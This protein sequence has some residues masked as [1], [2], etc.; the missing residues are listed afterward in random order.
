MGMDI[1]LADD[2]FSYVIPAIV[3]VLLVYLVAR[4]RRVNVPLY[5]ILAI[6]PVVPLLLLGDLFIRPHKDVLERLEQLER[7]MGGEHA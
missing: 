7:N 2:W 4:S 5:T 1:R 3:Q 6:I